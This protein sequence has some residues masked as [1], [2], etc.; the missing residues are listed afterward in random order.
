[1]PI[2][3]TRPIVPRTWHGGRPYGGVILL[4]GNL[5]TLE[6][7]GGNDNIFNPNVQLGV[8]HCF[9]PYSQFNQTSDYV[10]Y[11]VLFD[12]VAFDAGIHNKRLTVSYSGAGTESWAN[13]LAQHQQNEGG[14]DWRWFSVTYTYQA[15]TAFA[16]GT[17]PAQ[18][19]SLTYGTTEVG[20]M[21]HVHTGS[22]IIEHWVLY[23]TFTTPTSGAPFDMV[24]VPD[25]DLNWVR[26]KA[27]LGSQYV[28]A[29]VSPINN[30]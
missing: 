1:M 30:V 9:P 6:V 11:W 4:P 23:P 26:A 28:Q 17:D 10:E 8:I 5:S 25:H 29:N 20:R 13:L 27:P 21:G 22:S 7:K 24:S 14:E 3:T 18:S 2:L 12:H 19:V 16:G 15:V